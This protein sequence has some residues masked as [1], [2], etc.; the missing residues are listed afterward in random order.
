MTQ[1]RIWTKLNLVQNRAIGVAVPMGGPI[2]TFHPQRTRS[3]PSGLRPIFAV[4]AGVRPS[5]ISP[6]AASIHPY[7]PRLA[8]GRNLGAYSRI[9]N[10]Q[11]VVRRDHHQKRVF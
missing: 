5:F 9:P 11:R 6:S 10:L 3:S 1:N 4:R 7:S 2:P 8:K